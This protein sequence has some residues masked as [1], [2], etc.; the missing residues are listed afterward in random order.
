MNKQQ[1]LEISLTE[2]ITE[3]KK[4]F[5]TLSRYYAV[6]QYAD[7]L[8][9]VSRF[10]KKENQRIESSLKLKLAQLIIISEN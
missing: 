7:I 4:T 1:T 6:K 2:V 9:K 5:P 3:A 10:S 8:D